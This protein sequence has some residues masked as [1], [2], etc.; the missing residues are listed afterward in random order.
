MIDDILS[1]AVK[2]RIH[3]TRNNIVSVPDIVRALLINRC[4][5]ASLHRTAFADIVA[6][7]LKFR[8]IC[9]TCNAF[10]VFVCSD[11]PSMLAKFILMAS[12]R[13]RMLPYIIRESQRTEVERGDIQIVL[14]KY[15]PLESLSGVVKTILRGNPR[16]PFV[17][18]RLAL[19]LKQERLRSSSIS[20]D[21]DGHVDAMELLLALVECATADPTF[22]S[23]P[24]VD[25]LL[26]NQAVAEGESPRSIVP[27]PVASASVVGSKLSLGHHSD[28][29][30][31]RSR[32]DHM[33]SER[34][35]AVSAELQRRGAT[36]TLMSPPRP[37]LSSPLAS[38]TEP[39]PLTSSRAADASGQ[40]RIVA[41][42]DATVDEHEAWMLQRLTEG[43][44]LHRQ[45]GTAERTA[46]ERIAVS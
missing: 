36:R 21:L 5:V 11:E 4:G 34:C 27:E 25:A 29:E 40:S 28:P 33:T 19:W 7:S 46:L 10:Y 32:S 6:A 35:A 22:R 15:I 23:S 8:S 37:S 43:L 17:K 42:A 31:G 24:S 39:S 20:F 38:R 1:L 26:S 14:R 45:G 2:F 30:A 3:P 18:T 41:D 16:A 12:M 13:L 44:Q 9:P